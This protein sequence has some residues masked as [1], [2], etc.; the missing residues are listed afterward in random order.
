MSAPAWLTR[1]F[2]GGPAPRWKR[3]AAPLPLAC[4]LLLAALLMVYARTRGYD[5]AAY[6]ENVA[7]LR[8]MKQLDAHWELDAM[9]S[10]IGLNQSYDP[11][12]DPLRDLN[13][14]PQQ[15]RGGASRAPEQAAELARSVAAYQDALHDKAA[16]VES[17]KSHNAVLRNS[18]AFLPTAGDDIE[19]L[20]AG[21]HAHAVAVVVQ[22]NRAL[23]ATLVYYHAP[24]DADLQEVADELAQL[25][26]LR[27]GADAELGERIDIFSAHARTVL[28]EQ[29]VVTRLLTGI[30]AA[31]TAARI[32]AI[33]ALLSREQHAAVQRLQTYRLYLSLLAATLAALLLVAALRLARDHAIINRVNAALTHANDHLEQRVRLRTVELSQANDSL[34]REMAE[35]RQLEGR[36]MQ[37]EK[38]AS[39]GQLAAGIAHEINNPLAFVASNF[40]MLEGYLPDLFAMLDAYQAAERSVVPSALAAELGRTRQ[41]L[42]LAFLRQDIPVLMAE[43]KDGLERVGK[44]VRDLK[45]FSRVDTA[46]DWEWT[47][48]RPGLASTLNIIAR[49]VRQAADVVTDYGALPAIECLPSQLNQVFMNL[50]LNAAHAVGPERGVITVRT[51]AEADEVWVEVS[52]TGCGIPP[53]VLPRI[54]DPFFTTKAIG[55]GTGLGLSL[56]YG[57]VQNHNGRIE[58]DTKVGQGTTFRVVLPV[59]RQAGR[60]EALALV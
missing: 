20:A 41:R 47:D 33:N 52:D 5:D 59:R 35:R 37:S 50:I 1:P 2:G 3:L 30:S 11:L 42:D 31:P 51:G 36:L 9:K 12:V 17:F 54:F 57:I 15:L 13:L 56:S 43:S 24:S 6:F 55:K 8:Q 14:T 4:V 23:L 16:L 21:A 18:L 39:I 19:H 10:R 32:D 34:Q 48:L 28:R 45:D 49:D 22:A 27:T 40:S 46:Q 53:A 25:A 60:E 29:S 58:I 44:I 26:R 7:R 38:L